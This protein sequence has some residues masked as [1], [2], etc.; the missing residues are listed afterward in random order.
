LPHSS[1]GGTSTGGTTIGGVSGVSS[2]S[3]QEA[4]KKRSNTGRRYAYF[5]EAIIRLEKEK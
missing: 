3:L 2:P 5:I 4:K 1:T